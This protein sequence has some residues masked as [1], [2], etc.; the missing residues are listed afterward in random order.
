M[1]KR[2]GAAALGSLLFATA[3]TAHVV[4]HVKGEGVPPQEAEQV[5]FNPQNGLAL[6]NAPFKAEFKGLSLTQKDEQAL[7]NDIRGLNQI[8]EGSQVKL[9]GTIDGEPFKAAVKNHK[10]ELDVKLKGIRFGSQQEAQAFVDSLQQGGADRIKVKGTI[11]GQ[12]FTARFDDHK[13]RVVEVFRTNGP[14][15]GTVITTASGR[16]VVAGAK[17]KPDPSV[18]AAANVASRGDQGGKTLA[19]PDVSGGSGKSGHVKQ[20]KP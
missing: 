14:K 19:S 20:G 1:I 4:I 18:Q 7:L 9:Q 10:G 2:I 17:V 6:G 13:G 16:T 12:R 5:L 11:D 15:N 3:A 8:P